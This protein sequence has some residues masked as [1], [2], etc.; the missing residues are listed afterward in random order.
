MEATY[1][2]HRNKLSVARNGNSLLLIIEG[3]QIQL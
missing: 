3:K 2:L 1:V